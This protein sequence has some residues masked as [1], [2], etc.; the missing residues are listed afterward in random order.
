MFTFNLVRQHKHLAL[1]RVP[2]GGWVTISGLVYRCLMETQLKLLGLEWWASI[3]RGGGRNSRE[4][5]SCLGFVEKRLKNYGMSRISK[6]SFL[7]ISF[8]ES[9][10]F[11]RGSTVHS[12]VLHPSFGDTITIG[13]GRGKNTSLVSHRKFLGNNDVYGGS[14]H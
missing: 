10:K 11:W 6:F 7:F 4:T 5:R 12:L 2:S 14:G 13:R 3:F 1:W 8:L 9:I